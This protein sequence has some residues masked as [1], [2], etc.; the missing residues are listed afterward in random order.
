M[1]TYGRNVYRTGDVL[2][3]LS[4]LVFTVRVFLTERVP[5]VRVFLTGLIHTVRVFRTGLV[6]TVRAFL[7]GLVPTVRVF[8]P[9]L[10]PTVPHDDVVLELLFRR[11]VLPIFRCPKS[12]NIFIYIYV[13]GCV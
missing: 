10:V 6:P 8:L 4:E 5:T 7:P 13:H 1:N 11:V 9:G 3:F 12:M 2:V